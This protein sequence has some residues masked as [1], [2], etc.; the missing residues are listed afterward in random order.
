MKMAK[1]ILT[2]DDDNKIVDLLEKLL[3]PEGFLVVKAGSGKEAIGKA[4]KH[5]PDLL[6]LDVM[7]EDTTGG[8]LYRKI[9][10]KLKKPIPVIFLTG[11]ITSSEQKEQLGINIGNFTYETLSKPFKPPELIAL[12][13]KYQ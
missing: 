1:T 4:E 12:A 10:Q 5:N 7:L 9:Q 6:I 8:D 3:V 11:L 13:R 2:V